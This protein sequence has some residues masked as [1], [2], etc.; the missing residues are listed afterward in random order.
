MDHPPV[1]TG[2]WN[3][4][5][6][7][8]SEGDTLYRNA[9]V[10]YDQNLIPTATILFN[11]F[12][13]IDLHPLG[14]LKLI[15]EI[16]IGSTINWG[17]MTSLP[18]VQNY[19]SDILN[20]NGIFQYDASSQTASGLINFSAP[21]GYAFT[22]N[23]FP[24]FFEKVY[25]NIARNFQ[26]QNTSAI[27]GDSVLVSYFALNKDQELNDAI[28]FSTFG[29]QANLVRTRLNLQT[30]ELSSQQI[31]SASGS[32]IK[33]RVKSADDGGLYRTGLVRG[34]NTPVSVSGAEV[35]MTANDSLFHV[36]ITK[37][38]EWGTTEWLTE[39]YAY[40]N[41]R[42][43]TGQGDELRVRSRFFTILETQDA[44]FVSGD[45]N[46]KSNMEDTL[47]FRDCFGEMHF[48]HN[49][50]T[51]YNET[52]GEY[53]VPLRSAMVYKLALTGDV[54]GRLQV[55][56]SVDNGLVGGFPKKFGIFEIGGKLAWCLHYSE[57]DNMEMEF[58]YTGAD[59]TSESAI[60]EIPEGRG[61]AIVWLDTDLFISDHWLIPYES[62]HDWDVIDINAILPYK[63]DTLLIQGSIG[64]TVT[65]TLDPFGNSEPFTTP[66]NTANGFF[67]FY[68]APQ[69]LANT[70]VNVGAKSLVLY[71]NPTKG[72]LYVSNVRKDDEAFRI[73]DMSGRLLLEGNMDAGYPIDVSMLKP[74]M[75]IFSSTSGK[76]HAT[77]KFVVK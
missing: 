70:E 7:E 75:Y 14:D 32:Q 19:P 67:A 69:I 43:D 40:N 8:V 71:P 72:L 24:G 28:S 68:S 66:A 76:G 65:T 33:F 58:G 62:P 6:L 18:P 57:A 3:N 27:I 55:M 29:G 61:I 4:N 73:I 77:E 10:V 39:L 35:P 34:N 21:Q 44:V 1:N 49:G 20:Q 12:G 5:Y 13:V 50:D 37:E 15:T 46:T 25:G 59:G 26:S 48:H 38:N 2:I 17:G 36:Y 64:R 53:Q 42:A 51:L 63:G 56:P 9:V 47:V 22:Y 23:P 52:F 11:P 74:G 45:L 41:T 60:I 54:E 31:G 30:Q 16:S